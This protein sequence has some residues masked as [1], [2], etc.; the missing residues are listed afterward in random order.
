M[1]REKLLTY[2]PI[3]DITATQMAEDNPSIAKDKIQ[4][5]PDKI[6]SNPSIAQI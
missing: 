4:D 5:V 6:F 3:H 1:D 2:L